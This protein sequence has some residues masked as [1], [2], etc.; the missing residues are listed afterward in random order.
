MKNK[1]VKKAC[2]HNE[3]EKECSW[4]KN[5]ID[6]LFRESKSR[7]VDGIVISSSDARWVT[8]N[9]SV[10]EKNEKITS[11]FLNTLDSKE[12]L[13]KKKSFLKGGTMTVIWNDAVNCT[14]KEECTENK[15]N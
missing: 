13:D 9:K 15:N 10:I 12:T 11:I 6:Q 3:K 14:K 5:K 4:K 8:V 1:K 7:N 2:V